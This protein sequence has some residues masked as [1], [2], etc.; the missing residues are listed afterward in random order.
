VHRHRALALLILLALAGG[1][2]LSLGRGSNHTAGP[3]PQGHHHL[4]ALSTS[5]TNPRLDPDWEG[6][7]KPVVMA[8]LGPGVPALL[9]GV[10]LSMVNLQT[11]LT[12]GTCPDPLPKTYDSSAPTSARTALQSAG[13]SLVTEANNLRGGLRAGRLGEL[14]ERPHVHRPR[15]DH[16]GFGGHHRHGDIAGPAGRRA[17]ALPGHV[18]RRAGLG[19]A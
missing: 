7:G 18:T 9:S 3:P 12:D 4:R 13:V 14:D 19:A 11:A 6:D 8:A 17:A 10:N 2:W 15:P 1:L 5:K 16:G